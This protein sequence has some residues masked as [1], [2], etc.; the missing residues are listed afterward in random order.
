MIFILI[1]YAEFI[2]GYNT[3]H[4]INNQTRISYSLFSFFL[5]LIIDQ[6]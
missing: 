3:Q 1:I 6:K 4:Q 2:H 5:V